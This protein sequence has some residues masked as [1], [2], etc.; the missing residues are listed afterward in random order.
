MW[1]S[2][3]IVYEAVFSHWGGNYVTNTQRGCNYVIM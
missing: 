2:T 3:A 1:E